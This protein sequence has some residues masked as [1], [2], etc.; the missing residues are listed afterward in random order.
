MSAPPILVIKA[1]QD[2]LQK[3]GLSVWT[4]RIGGADML[5]GSLAYDY[6]NVS[7]RFTNI[8]LHMTASPIAGVSRVEYWWSV[9]LLTSKLNST[10]NEDWR[11][12]DAVVIGD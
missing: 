5:I 8:S 3:L 4:T 7:K 6:W 1:F 10:D 12:A 11:M 9:A 2:A